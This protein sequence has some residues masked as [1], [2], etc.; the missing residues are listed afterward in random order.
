MVSNRFKW[1]LLFDNSINFI[2]SQVYWCSPWYKKLLW[3]WSYVSINSCQ[4]SIS[5]QMSPWLILQPI[6]NSRLQ[7][8]SSDADND[9]DSSSSSDFH[10]EYFKVFL[11]DTTLSL[12]LTATFWKI[13]EL[14][15]RILWKTIRY[16]TIT[17]C[18]YH[19]I[20]KSAW[21]QKSCKRWLST[22][23]RDWNSQVC[24]YQKNDD[25]IV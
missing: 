13:M 10:V 12:A 21:R 24:S 4:D 9:A 1:I 2:N 25:R 7:S 14:Y 18:K 17:W 19:H 20:N 11:F 15:W 22:N 23:P 16:H 5:I 8:Y 3:V 6:I